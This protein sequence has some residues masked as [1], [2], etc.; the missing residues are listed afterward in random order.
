MTTAAPITQS[1]SRIVLSNPSFRRLWA[2][3][4]STSTMRWLETLALGAFVYELTED[5]FKV[6]LVF[7][8]RMIPMFALGAFIGSFSDRVNRK[9][10]LVVAAA[11]L[12]AVYAALGISVVTDHITLW[13]IYLGALFAGIVWA[14]DFPVRRAMIG[15]VVARENVGAA[16]GLD[17]AT[18]SFTRI[19]G[20]L[21]GGL[22]L[23]SV[24]MGA[25]YF[26]GAALFL[27]SSIIALTLS[28]S[29]PEKSVERVNP[30]RNIA[31]G[32]SYIRKDTVIMT[33]LT[34]TIIMNMFAFPYQS[35]VPVITDE[36]L[37]V[38]DLALGV[39]VS[40]E[41]LGATIGALLI[42]SRST[43]ARYTR[44]FVFGS[45][46][47]LFVIMAFSRVPWYALALPLMFVG[48]FGMSGFGTMQSILIVSTTPP[49]VRG[50]VLGVLAVTIGTGPIAALGLGL[51]ARAAGA[52][53]ALLAMSLTG[54]ALLGITLLVNPSFLRLRDAA[55][56]EEREPSGG[57]GLSE[58]P[59]RR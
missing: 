46:F 4:G 43:P 55:P 23:A 26:M 38:G 35:M 42:A 31:E 56:L 36:V 10:L 13:Q 44:I 14:T 16:L 11:A 52:P 17:L 59:A 1:R 3:G 20:P 53:F 32:F 48:G 5:E 22:F 29:P 57:R 27:A 2:M 24:G 9:R 45:I 41:G 6:A 18:N 25:V 49:H 34:I 7:F 40:V 15:D 33:V 39:L 51:L 30:L 19:P 50:R 58:A 12:S 8:C 21:L 47:F 28:Y 37:G 54:F